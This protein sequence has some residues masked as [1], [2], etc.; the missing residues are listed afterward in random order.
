MPDLHVSDMGYVL[1]LRHAAL[2][3]L[4]LVRSTVP[5]VRHSLQ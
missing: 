1:K 2:K 5:F 3:P 4:V